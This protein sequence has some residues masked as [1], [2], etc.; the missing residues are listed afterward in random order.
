MENIG[1]KVSPLFCMMSINSHN[2]KINSCE[3]NKKGNK[4][5]SREESI[6]IVVKLLRLIHKGIVSQ[7]LMN[8]V[9][10]LLAMICE[11]KL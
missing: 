10:F 5:K 9:I 6:R 2:L 1:F 3:D 4:H 8:H 7:K 11:I